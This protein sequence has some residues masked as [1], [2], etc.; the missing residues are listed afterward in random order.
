[1][2]LTYAILTGKLPTTGKAYADSSKVVSLFADGQKRMFTTNATTV[3]DVLNR[4]NIKLGPH[5]LV[6]PSAD[7]KIPTG[8]FNINIF[9][10]RPVL[11]V[12]GSSAKV[13]ETAYSSPRLISGDA[14]LST[15]PEDQ[16]DHDFVTNFVDDHAV[17]EKVIIKRSK[18]VTLV[19]DGT[20]KQLRTQATSVEGFIKEKGIPMGEKDT[21]SVPVTAPLTAGMEFSITRVAEVTVTKQETLPN[22]TKRIS[23][24]ALY[25]GETQVTEEGS[26]GS[27]DVTYKISYHNGV[28][29]GRQV[30]SVANLVKPVTRVIHVG[31]KIREDSW[32]RL[33]VCESGND[34]AKNS[35]N[36]YYGAY[37]FDISTW[38]SNGGSGRPD[39]AS[40]ATQDLIAKRVQARRGWSPWPVC[41][42]RLGL[43]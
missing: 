34:Y 4:T 23:D 9:R 26:A 43:T 27:K 7:T 1:L 32:Y 11:V 13:I 8:Y 19:V 16:F 17:G 20:T 39:Q 15:Y 22:A 35:G 41:S 42:V 10:A 40:P 30:L 33:R 6:E 28:E 24:P 36:G 5:D 12:D 21:T 29:V 2:F 31:T 37:Q 38:Q 25:Q 3:G 14:G 18:P